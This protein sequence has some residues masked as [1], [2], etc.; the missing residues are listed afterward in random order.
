MKGQLDQFWEPIEKPKDGN[1]I[2]EPGYFYLMATRERVRFSKNMS[3]T[4][5]YIDRNAFEGYVHEA[6]FMDIGFGFGEKGEVPATHI[7]LEMRV[8]E[9]FNISHGQYI[10]KIHFEPSLDIPRDKEGKIAVY[11]TGIY[12]LS[13]YQAQPRGPTL[14]KQ[15]L[16]PK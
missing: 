1:L 11:G 5:E 15:F 13:N 7:T 14:G 8:F 2:L 3:G 10:G 4:L 9:P 6:G 16:D 12:A